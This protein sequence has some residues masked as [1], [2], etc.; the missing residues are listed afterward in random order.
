MITKEEEASH[1]THVLYL[2][3]LALW[4]P[5]SPPLMY[6]LP[7]LPYTLHGPTEAPRAP[8]KRR[9]SCRVQSPGALPLKG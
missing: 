6:V 4:Y 9:P 7:G 1:T 8:C 5:S 3:L 2:D